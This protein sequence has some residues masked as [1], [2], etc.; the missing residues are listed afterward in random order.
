MQLFSFIGQKSGV[1]DEPIGNHGNPIWRWVNIGFP[2]D[3]NIGFWDRGRNSKI[4]LNDFKSDPKAASEFFKR[5]IKEKFFK[6]GILG[7]VKGYIKKTYWQW[8][9][10]SYSIY[11]YNDKSIKLKINQ[12]AKYKLEKEIEML[13]IRKYLMYLQAYNWLIFILIVIYL[14]VSIMKKDFSLGV[15]FYII[16]AYIGFYLIWEIKPRYLFGLYPIFVIISTNVAI[17]LIESSLELKNIYKNL[18]RKKQKI[19]PNS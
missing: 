7:T 4:F 3:E 2:A 16:L 6:L 12:I 10:G 1:L 15:F 13:S 14:I 17:G 8:S 11:N 18:I 5:D 9:I 19:N